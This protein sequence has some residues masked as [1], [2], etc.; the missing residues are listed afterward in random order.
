MRKFLAAVLLF[1]CL[2]T[3]CTIVRTEDPNAV[4]IGVCLKQAD[5]PYRQALERVLPHAGYY[6]NFLSGRNDQSVQ[7]KQIG[8]LIEESYDLLIVEPVMAA[9][10]EDISQFLQTADMPAVLLGSFPETPVPTRWPKVCHVDFDPLQPGQLQGKCILNTPDRGDVNCDG[11]VTCAF[12]TGP[13]DHRDTA[14]LQTSCLETLSAAGLDVRL[15]ESTAGDHTLQRSKALTEGLLSQFGKEVE[16][17]FC[18]SEQIV[19]GV[20][21]ALQDAGYTVNEDIYVVGIGGSADL[22]EKVHAGTL[23]GT[24]TADY[25]ALAQQVA[26]AAAQLLTGTAQK[27]Y[28]IDFYLVETQQKTAG[29][30]F[31]PRFYCKGLQHC[32]QFSK[33][34]LKGCTVPMVFHLCGSLDARNRI[35]CSNTGCII[36]TVTAHERTHKGGCINIACTM[37]GIRQFIVFI[38]CVLTLFVYHNAGLAGGIGNTGKNHIPASQG[39]QS[40]QNSVNVGPVILGP[41]CDTGQKTTFRKIGHHIISLGT[42]T[43]H[44]LHEGCI[45]AGVKTAVVCH[46]GI[47]NFYT[48]RCGIIPENILNIRNLL[49]AAQIAGIDSLERNP[50]FHP[51]RADRRDVLCQ[52]PKS[53][54]GETGSMG[55]QHRGGKD[56]G[57]QTAGR[58]NR[59]RHSQRALTYTR[60]ILN[61][62]DL[63]IIHGKAPLYVVVC[64]IPLTGNKNSTKFCIIFKASFHS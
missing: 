15:L 58:Q 26:D 41:I 31:F 56:T 28:K 19:L 20:L 21:D 12:L 10:A 23:T 47:H 17:L 63:F 24:V 22:L 61:R 38:I 49:G 7:N 13:E 30:F 35:I 25:E 54:P 33:D 16:V 37:T 32:D 48:A 42:Q 36:S 8:H 4:R 64:I 29:R 5:S 44:G 14:L 9:A 3:G 40:I 11:K 39:R 34:R 53:I 55:R 43:L 51:M 46:S 45:K 62:K 1:N 52:V 18:G 60:N 50:L 6:V 2:L 57:L 27:S 59:Q